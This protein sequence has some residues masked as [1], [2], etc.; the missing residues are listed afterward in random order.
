[1]N[2]ITVEDDIIAKLK[3]D[4]TTV[5][6][7]PWPDNPADFKNL[8]PTGAILVRYD[9]S[10]YI[11]PIPNSSKII[12]HDRSSNWGISIIQ[13]NLRETKGH[14]G[15]YTLLE[16]I[17]SALTGYT[18]TGLDDASVMYPTSDGFTREVAGTWLYKIVFTFTFP[19]AES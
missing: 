4:I 13:E 16:S 1:M 15:V 6:V 18:I 12:V 7:V 9:G 17:R 19:E 8:H 14:Q 11:T 2:L 3:A 10:G 5:E